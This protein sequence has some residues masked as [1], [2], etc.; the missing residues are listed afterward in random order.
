MSQPLFCCEI[1]TIR[2]WEV[3]ITTGEQIVINPIDV[4]VRVLIF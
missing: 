3:A 2:S 4:I 1:I